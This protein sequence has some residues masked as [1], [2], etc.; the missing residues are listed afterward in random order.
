MIISQQIQWLRQLSAASRDEIKVMLKPMSSWVPLYDVIIKY[1]EKPIHSRTILRNELVLEIDNNSW[2]L[3]RDGTRKIIALLEKWQGNKA[4]YLSFSGNRSIHVHVFIDWSSVTIEPETADVLKG[5]DDVISTM[6]HFWTRQ[7]ELGTGAVLD[8]Q[9]TGKHLIRMEGGFN[10]KSNKYCTMLKSI[11]DD[12]PDYYDIAIPGSLPIERWKLSQ[13]SKAINGFLQIHFKPHESYFT[14]VGRPIST[15]DIPAILKPIFI[16]GHRHAIVMA[17]TGWL[18]RHGISESE[19]L[20]IIKEINPTD[21]TQENPKRTIHD[22]FTA[23]DT[24]RIPGLP[25][26]ISIIRDETTHGEISHVIGE[27][28]IHAL[29]RIMSEEVIEK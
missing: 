23:P 3:V 26:L 21:K 27:D 22:I 15:K 25:K 28:A 10:E 17:L 8:M 7:F 16:P 5:H 2:P 14:G 29:D 4:Y 18:K 19:A 20:R 1:P 9:L 24:A 11:P 13:F 6:K 12:K